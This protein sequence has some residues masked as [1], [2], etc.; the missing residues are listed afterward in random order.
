MGVKDKSPIILT[1]IFSLVLFSKILC[2]KNMGKKMVEKSVIPSTNKGAEKGQCCNLNMVPIEIIE[3][4]MYPNAIRNF[5]I[6][7]V[8]GVKG[9]G[10]N[11]FTG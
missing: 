8:L 5:F 2:R 7:F 3:I 9:A 4:T 10:I 6:G 11:E 1:A